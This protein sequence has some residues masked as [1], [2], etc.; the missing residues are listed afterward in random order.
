MG[1]TKFLLALYLI[2]L[3]LAH[4][5]LAENDQ[6]DFLSGHNAARAEVGVPPLKWNSTLAAYAQAYANKRSVDCEM[7]ESDPMGRTENV[8]L[9]VMMS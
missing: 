7:V 8:L 5:S 6:Q 4:V 9:K 2:G 3:T 1:F